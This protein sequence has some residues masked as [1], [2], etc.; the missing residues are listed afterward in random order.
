MQLNSRNTKRTDAV[1][2]VLLIVIA[3]LAPVVSYA[4]VS[5]IYPDSTITTDVNTSPPITWAQGADYSQ[6]ATSGFAGSFATSDN[7]SAY[8]VAVSGLSGGTVTIDKLVD[9]I[10]TAGVS[11]FKVKISSALSGTLTAPTT[12][13]LRFWTGATA[14]TADGDAQVAAVLDLTAAVDTETATTVAGDQ[15]VFIQLVC[16]Y[17]SSTSGSSTVSI[18]PSSIILS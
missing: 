6:A 18:Q 7:A 4:G 17:S 11:T 3:I 2:Y 15:T 14:P 5:L 13:K 1:L 8:T 9:V 12:L 10:A 16:E